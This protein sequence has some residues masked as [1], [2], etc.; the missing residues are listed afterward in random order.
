MGTIMNIHQRF[1]KKLLFQP[2]LKED[3]RQFFACCG[4]RDEQKFDLLLNIF[5]SL[6]ITQSVIFVN[7]KE[8]VKKLASQLNEIDYNVLSMHGDMDLDQKEAIMKDFYDG[9][10]RILVCT[11][12]LA[13]STYDLWL[14]HARRPLVINYDL[15]KVIEKYVRKFEYYCNY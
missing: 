5:R 11:D 13:R 2:R 10:N 12:F 14:I 4:E 8:R 15:P 1:N 7:S 6:F 9:K 3:I